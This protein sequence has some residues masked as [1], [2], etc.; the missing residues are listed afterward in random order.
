MVAHLLAEASISSLTIG[1]TELATA[2]LRTGDAFIRKFLE[3]PTIRFE[4]KS[5]ITHRYSLLSAPV[6]GDVGEPQSI[7]AVGA[8][9]PFDE[10]VVDGGRAGF[11]VQTSFL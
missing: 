5:L 1:G 8:E 10:V 4:C 7:R 9:L 6:F 2:L 3:W 11:P